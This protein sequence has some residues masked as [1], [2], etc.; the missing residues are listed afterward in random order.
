MYSE[1]ERHR[2]SKQFS[3]VTVHPQSPEEMQGRL[4]IVFLALSNELFTLVGSFS[5]VT[6]LLVWGHG[7]SFGLNAEEAI[8]EGLQRTMVFLASA[9]RETK[10]NKN[11]RTLAFFS[12]SALA[13]A[14]ATAESFLCCFP[15]HSDSH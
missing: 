3:G 2:T 15:I 7:D 14:S 4:D 5:K 9:M 13:L 12:F 1:P 8:S 11:Q 6:F 10:Y